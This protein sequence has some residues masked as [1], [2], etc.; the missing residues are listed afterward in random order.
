MGQTKEACR[1][2]N[3]GSSSKNTLGITV[4][5]N[6]AEHPIV[7]SSPPFLFKIAERFK[8]PLHSRICRALHFSFP[9]PTHPARVTAIN[10]LC[11]SGIS[12]HTTA[13]NLEGLTYAYSLGHFIRHA[14]LAQWVFGQRG[15]ATAFHHSS[16]N[17]CVTIKTNW[18]T[19]GW[20]LRQLCFFCFPREQQQG[21]GQAQQQMET[22]LFASC[23]S[24]GVEKFKPSKKRKIKKI[25]SIQPVNLNDR[26]RS[27]CLSGLKDGEVVVVSAALVC[28]SHLHAHWTAEKHCG[29]GVGAGTPQST[30]ARCWTLNLG[31]SLINDVPTT[32]NYFFPKNFPIIPIPS[33]PPWPFHHLATCHA[34]SPPSFFKVPHLI[35]PPVAAFNYSLGVK[36][37][38]VAAN[39][40]SISRKFG[41]AVPPP[42]CWWQ[43]NK[44]PGSSAMMP[45]FIIFRKTNGGTV[46]APYPLPPSVSLCT[47]LQRNYLP[48]TSV[49]CVS[50][51]SERRQFSS[52]GTYTFWV[53]APLH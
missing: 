43:C 10:G 40:S 39:A 17:L 1:A 50:S 38:A 16:G 49:D 30:M 28:R 34:H 19:L 21:R 44:N 15:P 20:N 6:Y 41:R 32:M 37:Q 31:E 42:S 18:K 8:K 52:V 11:R 27:T 22:R 36:A 51:L 24:L 33:H 46:K 29:A 3:A 45:L 13:P 47:H 14:D 23:I 4:A 2:P 5:M 9:S 12:E 53:S 25:E 26:M 48:S 35:V 7:G